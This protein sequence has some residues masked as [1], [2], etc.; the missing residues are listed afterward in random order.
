MLPEEQGSSQLGINCDCSAADGASD[1]ATSGGSCA[2]CAWAGEEGGS[3]GTGGGCGSGCGKDR[4]GWDAGMARLVASGSDDS[5]AARREGGCS[6][7]LPPSMP[8]VG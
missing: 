6:T 2:D 8:V 1:A 5:A 3:C 7:L 4:T